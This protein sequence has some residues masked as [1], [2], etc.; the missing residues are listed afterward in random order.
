MDGRS[1][2][3]LL[4]DNESS[5]NIISSNVLYQLGWDLDFIS[6][7][8]S[9]IQAFNNKSSLML[10]TMDISLKIGVN[11]IITCFLV[12]EDMTEHNLLLGRPWIHEMKCVVSTLHRC[13]KYVYADIVQSIHIDFRPFSHNSLFHIH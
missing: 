1:I 2:K 9:E 13:L 5:I 7:S 4:I 8:L 11:I 6:H 10:D 3:K 12:I